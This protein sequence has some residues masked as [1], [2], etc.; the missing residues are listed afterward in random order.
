MSIWNLDLSKYPLLTKISTPGGKHVLN[1]Y[2]KLS[3]HG[4]HILFDFQQTNDSELPV[5]LRT[6]NKILELS[7]LLTHNNNIHSAS[8]QFLKPAL[9]NFLSCQK[10]CQ[11]ICFFINNNNNITFLVTI[12]VAPLIALS[13][14]KCDCQSPFVLLVASLPH[15]GNLKLPEGND[16]PRSLIATSSNTWIAM[17][18]N[19][20]SRF[21]N[22][23]QEIPTKIL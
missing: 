2:I 14:C 20:Q 18:G 21:F 23:P 9:T 13:P 8:N 5:L 16:Q 15:K 19:L 6:S 12:I 4:T 17:T 10:N 3:T 22:C 1:T 11:Q 7:K